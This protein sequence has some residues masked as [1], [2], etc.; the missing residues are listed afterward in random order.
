M[1]EPKRLS[2]IITS[3]NHAHYLPQAIS[4]A[5]Q[6]DY[7]NKEIIVVD[8]G[9]TDNTKEV[10]ARFPDIKYVYQT[11]TGLSAARNTGIDHSTG[12][13]LVFLDADDW[14]LENAF[15]KSVAA[16]EANHDA[17]FAYGTH[18][19]LNEKNEELPSKEKQDIAQK[20][21]GHLLVHNFIAMHAAVFYRRW[22]FDKFRFDTNLKAC[23]D[24]DLFLKITRNH[25][26][27]YHQHKVAAYRKHSENMSGNVSLMIETG[28][29]VMQRQLP[30]LQNEEERKQSAKGMLFWK[31]Y[32]GSELHAQLLKESFLRIDKKRRQ[33]LL[34]LFA[35]GKRLFL[36]Y[37]TLKLRMG[38]KSFIRRK[39]PA[40]L[41]SLLHSNGFY[42]GY[43]PATGKIRRGDFNTT[44][45]FSTNFGYE[46]GGPVDR[47]YIEN[48]LAKNAADIKGR[49]LE[50]GDNEYT[51]R[52]GGD[53]VIKS[54]VLHV[55]DNNAKAT[56]IGD[57]SNAPQLPGNTFDCIVLTQTLHL[58]YNHVDALHT[59]YRILKPGGVLL[60]T[61]PGITHID[62]GEWHD[63]WY[64]AYTQAAINRML[65]EV[66][67]ADYVQTETFGNV[68]V[69]TAFLYGM[70]LPEM[71]KE[72]M[73]AHDPHYQVIITARAAK[74]VL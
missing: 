38:I 40:I 54:D 66:F 57:L 42:K 70:G 3:Y 41:L 58:I 43:K 5:M 47:Y 20:H 30:F 18:I 25:P 51:L 16:L 32:Y 37:T 11:N 31:S 56:F 29:K 17:A 45:P 53:K 59:C 6:Q 19:K 44:Q 50:I 15:S 34:S 28:L 21:Y 46:R 73:D 9:S 49:V 61:V 13:Y 52:F 14:F 71:K 63:Y 72:E 1:S 23:E 39:T 7:A 8:D 60:L 64:W 22:V 62:R 65:K 69:A 36:D 48:F 74:P 26:V 35:C 12:E 55:E 33:D 2:V 68:L 10:V 4:S 67:P 27:V 24:Y